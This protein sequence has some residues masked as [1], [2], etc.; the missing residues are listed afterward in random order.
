MKHNYTLVKRKK[1]LAVG[2]EWCVPFM[3]G[4]SFF[5]PRLHAYAKMIRKAVLKT[6]SETQLQTADLGGQGTTSEVAHSI[7]QEIQRGGPCTSEQI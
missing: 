3:S 5:F 4:L 1:K 6:L 7:M 2:L